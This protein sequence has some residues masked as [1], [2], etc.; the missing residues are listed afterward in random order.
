MHLGSWLRTTFAFFS[1]VKVCH[2]VSVMWHTGIYLFLEATRSFIRTSLETNGCCATIRTS[3]GLNA[4][5]L[6]SGA[7]E[8][9]GV[10]HTHI[11]ICMC[12][13]VCLFVNKNKCSCA[14]VPGAIGCNHLAIAGRHC[15]SRLSVRLPSFFLT[16]Q[17]EKRAGVIVSRNP[18][19]STPL[20]H[21]TPT[22]VPDT[23]RRKENLRDL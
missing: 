6:I 3:L 17:G 7:E 15:S 22:G 21:A 18:R 2:G 13:Y 14:D 9:G 10:A 19:S 4:Y 20:Q 23:H 16:F 1:F 12:V 5:K 8:Q 11:H